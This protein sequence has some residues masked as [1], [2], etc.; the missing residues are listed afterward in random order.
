MAGQRLVFWSI[1][2]FGSDVT[3]DSPVVVDLNY[4]SLIRQYPALA[5]AIGQGHITS[6]AVVHWGASGPL[7][8]FVVDD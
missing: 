1:R 8:T 3:P 2:D 6:H 5:Q 7:I 4:N